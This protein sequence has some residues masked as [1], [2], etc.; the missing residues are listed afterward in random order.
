MIS[1]ILIYPKMSTDMQTLFCPLGA[2]RYINP[3]DNP[4]ARSWRQARQTSAPMT[5]LHGKE[6]PCGAPGMGPSSSQTVRAGGWSCR[7]DCVEFQ[8]STSFDAGP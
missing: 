4:D 3:V 8:T 5:D 6:T 1:S 2:R 7:S